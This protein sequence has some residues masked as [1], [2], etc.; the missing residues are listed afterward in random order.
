MKIFRSCLLVLTILSLFCG[1]GCQSKKSQPAEL[2]SIDLLRGDIVLC[3]GDEFGE[4]SFSLAC[5]EGTR[6]NFDL[7][8]SLLHSFEH[9]EAEKAFVKVLDVDPDCPMAYWGLAMCKIGHPKWAPSQKDFEQG[10]KILEIAK[11][12]PTTTRERDYLSAVGAYYDYKDEYNK[13]DHRI[14]S[15]K[16]EQKMGEIYEKYDDD[17]EA[18]ILYA[19]TLFSTADPKDKS[20]ASRKKAGLILESIF[21]D[22]PNHPGIAHY[23]I[24]NY[25]NPVLAPMALNSARSYA[26]IAPASAHAQHMPSHIFTRLGLWDESVQSNINS[27]SSAVCYAQE[28]AMDGHS[29]NETHAMD[30]LV[31]AY[32]QKGDN[33]KANEQFEHLKT[34]T[35]VSYASSP[36]NLWAIPARMVLEN[37]Q[38]SAAANL[39]ITKTNY[40]SESYPWEMAIVHFTRL[41]GSA[42]AGDLVSA[43]LEL[44][45]LQEL[46]E[47]LVAQNE[48]YQADQVMIQIKASQ[49]WMQFAKGNNEAAL[50][51]MTEAA[52][53]ED[54][55]EKHPITPGEVLP[56]RELL[57][58]LLLAMNKPSEALKAYE[59]DLKEHPKRFNGI[60]GA[61]IAAKKAGDDQKASRYF[62]ELIELT[63]MS[64]SDRPEVEEARQFVQRTAS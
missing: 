56:A 25:D 14:R 10:V 44:S 11:A 32:L 26:R 19:L 2:I 24:H 39:E 41:L 55:T 58:D 50:A 30:Y 1:I 28:V 27:A 6:E 40:L 23:I 13:T 16:M 3:G 22:Q 31:Y 45:K 12:L 49:A 33:Q 54:G 48:Q 15:Q 35:N 47:E 60:Y 61:A 7:A 42:H 5:K 38:W 36:Y 34:I 57:G 20:Y 53:M 43:E 37:K 51:R 64:N 4:V 9:E 62:E 18:A 52:D 17:K 8:V 63:K 29:G 59:L 21:P 46:H